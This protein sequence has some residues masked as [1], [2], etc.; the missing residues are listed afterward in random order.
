LE[1]GI[2]D[3]DLSIFCPFPNN[4]LNLTLNLKPQ[5]SN[6]KPQTM[7]LTLINDLLPL[8]LA[9]NPAFLKV[10]TDQHAQENIRIE[11]AIVY[12]YMGGTAVVAGAEA[13][14]PDASHQC[15][16]NLSE[17]FQNPLNPSFTYPATTTFTFLTQASALFKIVLS[18]WFGQP[19]QQNQAIT[20]PTDYF[21]VSGKIPE[22]LHHLFYD[23][24]S[25]LHAKITGGDARLS[26]E[27][28]RAAADA[29]TFERKVQKQDIIKIYIQAAAATTALKLE[30]HLVFTDATTA[31]KTITA[32]TQALK[33]QVVEIEAGHNFHDLDTWIATN[34]P[35]KT[36]ASYTA[37]ILDGATSLCPD[38]KYLVDDTYYP[39]RREFIFRNSLG[40]YDT[41]VATGQSE[42]EIQYEYELA[43]V[44]YWPQNANMALHR[45][46]RADTDPT[47]K[48]N[49]GHISKDKLEWLTEFFTST[50][51]WEILSG[52]LIPVVLKPAGIVQR[53]DKSGLYHADFEYR[54]SPDF[55]NEETTAPVIE[56]DIPEVGDLYGGGIVA[57]VTDT[58]TE[59]EIL[60][61]A[62]TY[63]SQPISWENANAQT[64]AFEGGGQT[65][66]RQPTKA[67]LLTIRMVIYLSHNAT[68]ELDDYYHWTSEDDGADAWARQMNPNSEDL[69]DKS[70]SFYFRPVRLIT[71]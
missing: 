68:A 37:K 5:T 27:H 9:E 67:E 23:T 3:L 42:T 66:W 63:P 43:N 65:D 29:K 53:R 36:L 8:R 10:E 69:A 25:S 49:T 19:P 15:F 6:L 50:D 47:I 11:C 28:L 7:P 38:H 33:G 12:A 60:I 61:L 55:E 41:F 13:L 52:K 48:A 18:E 54:H 20:I 71:I 1:F 17:Y 32:S 26:L 70:S 14:T 57:Q 62:L 40:A 16:F 4:P 39:H 45:N 64:A 22:S 44:P 24:F 21:P 30:L 56:P 46:L 31:T 2:W 34:H 59:H 51:V 35:G 58:G